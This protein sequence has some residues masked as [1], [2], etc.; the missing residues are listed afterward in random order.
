[1][2]SRIKV[3][4]KDI[5]SYNKFVVTVSGDAEALLIV[6]CSTPR[7]RNMLRLIY[8]LGKFETRRR[9]KSQVATSR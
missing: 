6:F 7:L 4:D 5:S 1:M 3:K 8:N 2:A 9:I